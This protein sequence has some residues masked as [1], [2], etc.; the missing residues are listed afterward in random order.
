MRSYNR[1]L[2]SFDVFEDNRLPNIEEN[3][4]YQMKMTMNDNGHVKVKTAMKEPGKEW[5]ID[6]QEYHQ[7]KENKSISQDQP[8]KKVEAI[9]Q[10]KSEK[11]EKSENTP[12]QNET[13][14]NEKVEPAKDNMKTV[15][16]EPSKK[17]EK[18]DNTQESKESSHSKGNNNQQLSRR[19]E[20]PYD[21]LQTIIDNFERDFENSIR[22][23]FGFYEP[24]PKESSPKVKEQKKERN[25]NQKQEITTPRYYSPF[26]EMDAIFQNMERDFGSVFG[27]RSWFDDP[28]FRRGYRDQVESNKDAKEEPAAEKAKDSESQKSEKAENVGN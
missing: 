10:A 13:K 3:T 2:R 19:R 28:F 25:D 8:Q 1:N 4:Y 7:N 21:E 5:A 15:S 20:D 14:S 23:H 24:R 11:S 22:R 18:A 6:F 9:D 12:Q 26:D 16:E 17:V 27:R